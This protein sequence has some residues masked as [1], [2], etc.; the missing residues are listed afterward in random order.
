MEVRVK[1]HIKKVD[2]DDEHNESEQESNM[3][4]SINYDHHP[5]IS[6]VISKIRKNL[7]SPTD[8]YLYLDNYWLPTWENSRILRD[9]DSIRVTVYENSKSKDTSLMKDQYKDFMPKTEFIKPNNKQIMDLNINGAKKKS[10]NTEKE[11]IS[12]PKSIEVND[13]RLIDN[14]AKN[15]QAHGKNKWKNSN[16][17][18]LNK[19]PQHIIFKSS[20]SDSS[21]SDSSEDDN[22]DDVN[23]HYFEEEQKAYSKKVD[24][25]NQVNLNKNRQ[26]NGSFQ[27]KPFNNSKP[28]STKPESKAINCESE[29]P[30]RNGNDSERFEIVSDPVDYEKYETIV[31]AP[32]L[33]DKIAFQVL[34]HC[35][36]LLWTC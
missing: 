33:N 36:K 13:N 2:D 20:S 32:N 19:K 35:P 31:G 8:M 6:D 27:Q 30:R 34:K 23:D 11:L 21:S 4:M 3:W 25:K 7:N 28:K 24:Y 18:D 10:N 1:L 26:N 9:N 12:K 5:T 17:N 15:I 22:D 16:S 29:K 14:I